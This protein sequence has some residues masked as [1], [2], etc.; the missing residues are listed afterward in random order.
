MN[1]MPEDNIYRGKILPE[2][3][4]DFLEERGGKGTALKFI[5]AVFWC[6]RKHPWT[7]NRLQDILLRWDRFEGVLWEL[8]IETFN[9][10][11][12]LWN[13]LELEAEEL[14]LKVRQ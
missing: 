6:H 5:K 13:R 12:A 1:E 14:N 8:E 10:D 7:T 2:H 4:Y 3:L 9:G 11:R